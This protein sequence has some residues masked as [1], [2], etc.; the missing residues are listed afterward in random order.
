MAHVLLG[1]HNYICAD[2][3]THESSIAAEHGP[4]GR[5]DLS[6]FKFWSKKGTIVERVQR[7]PSDIFGLPGDHHGVRDLWE[8][9]CARYGLKSVIWTIALMHFSKLLLIFIFTE[10]TSLLCYNL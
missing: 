9:H 4:L 5:D 10:K 3:K 8:A 2:L 1:F 6:V 7:T